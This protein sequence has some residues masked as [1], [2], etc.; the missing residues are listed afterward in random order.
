MAEVHLDD[1]CNDVFVGYSTFPG[2]TVPVRSNEGTAFYQALA[3]CLNNYYSSHSLQ[4]IC[5]F[6][7]KELMVTGDP[8]NQTILPKIST[9]TARVMFHKV[10]FTIT[11]ILCNC[12][13]M[14]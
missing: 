6:V 1:S 8:G 2:H 12:H 11:F 4:E 9:L 3:D 7:S 14:T 5:T 13:N 10:H